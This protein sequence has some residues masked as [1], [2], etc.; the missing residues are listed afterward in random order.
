MQLLNLPIFDAKIIE[1]KGK[2]CIFD[3]IRKKYVALTPEEWVRQHF[4]HFMINV[5][6]YPMGL[7]AVEAIVKVNQLR[8]RADIVLYNRQLQPVLIV[9]CKAPD[10]KVGQ[11]T[12]NQAGRYNQALG[13]SYLVVT[14]GLVSF[15]IQLDK[16]GQNHKLIT[17]LP[18]FDELIDVKA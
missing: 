8:Q 17:N 2:K 13:A 3:V 5:M 10:V 4:I 1:E 6:G 7:M 16:S 14:N 9:E 11:E 15:C 12:L 18:L